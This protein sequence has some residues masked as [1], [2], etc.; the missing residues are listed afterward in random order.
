MRAWREAAGRDPDDL[1][2][3]A[4]IDVAQ[5]TPDDWKRKAEGWREQG[6]THLSLV[7]M[8]GGLDGAEAHL[9]RLA[10]AREALSGVV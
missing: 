3:D 4:R 10:V 5:G 6:A 8:G 1:G 7:T 9:E 2:I